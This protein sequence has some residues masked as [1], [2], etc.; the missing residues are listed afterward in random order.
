MNQEKFLQVYKRILEEEIKKNPDNFAIKDANVV[1]ERM[2]PA[3]IKGSFDKDSA[4][5]RRTCRELGI[6]HTYKAIKEFITS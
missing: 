3:I 6:R 4:C 1:F 5:F 2:K